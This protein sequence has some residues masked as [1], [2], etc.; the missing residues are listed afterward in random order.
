MDKL[1][2][3]LNGF[4][5]HTLLGLAIMLWYFTR[6]MKKEHK[7]D[8]EKMTNDHKENIDR[9]EKR[10]EIISKRTDDLYMMFIKLLEKK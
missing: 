7:E 3:F 4:D 1:I 5:I 9:I 8:M 10:T 6:Q 2:D